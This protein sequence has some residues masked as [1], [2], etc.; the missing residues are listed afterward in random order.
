[1]KH[2][3]GLTVESSDEAEFINEGIDAITDSKSMYEL[4]YHLQR[5]L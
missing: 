4:D 5:H 3:S 2:Y 1:M